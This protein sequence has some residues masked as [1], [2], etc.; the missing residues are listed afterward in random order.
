MDCGEVKNM[1]R[2]GEKWFAINREVKV[3][4]IEKTLL[5]L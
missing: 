1:V 4:L 5:F 3:D 2:E